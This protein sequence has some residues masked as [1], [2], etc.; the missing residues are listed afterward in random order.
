MVWLRVICFCV[1]SSKGGTPLLCRLR[2]D[3][4]APV[5]KIELCT[6]AYGIYGDPANVVAL[7]VAV[8]D[9]TLLYFTDDIGIVWGPPT[10][11]QQGITWKTCT[12]VRWAR[13][14]SLIVT[15]NYGHSCCLHGSCVSCCQVIFLT[16]WLLIRISVTP[17]D[18]CDTCSLLSFHRSATSPCSM[19]LMVIFNYDYLVFEN[20]DTKNGWLIYHACL[21]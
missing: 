20:D 16:R 9:N 3:R 1:Q 11:T 21:A 10:D 12:R 6:D 13:L 19:R 17:L 14:D 15:M 2:T 4:L 7:T 8:L 18:M 5:N